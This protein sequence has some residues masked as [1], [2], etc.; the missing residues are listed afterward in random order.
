[1]YFPSGFE[2][3]LVRATEEYRGITFSKP[4]GFHECTSL[5]IPYLPSETGSRGFCPSGTA[6]GMAAGLIKSLSKTSKVKS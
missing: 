6:R 2:D 4:V 5:C 1:M 3:S